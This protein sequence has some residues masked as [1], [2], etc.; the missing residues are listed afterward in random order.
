MVCWSVDDC[1]QC[2]ELRYATSLWTATVLNKDM[3]PV[4]Y[5][6]SWSRWH[7]GFCL[8]KKKLNLMW[9]SQVVNVPSFIVRL[10]S[11]K[12]IDFSLKSPFGGNSRWS[13]PACCL[14]PLPTPSRWQAR[15]RQEEERQEGWRCWL[16]CRR[17]TALLAMPRKL[18]NK[19]L[20]FSLH[21]S[22]GLGA[23]SHTKLH[24]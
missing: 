10:D 4:H 2:L 16:W 6:Y 14:S 9:C 12:H 17:V 15:P 23:K 3:L 8:N 20:G 21:L 11:Q 7:S 19:A 13:Q 1:S 5:L 24:Y 18:R 22:A